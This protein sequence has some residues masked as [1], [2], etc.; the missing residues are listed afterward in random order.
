MTQDRTFDHSVLNSLNAHIAV[1]NKSG[2]IVAVND[3]WTRFAVKNGAPRDSL[4]G[5]GVNYLDVCRRSAAEGD[6]SAAQALSG[7]T[8]VSDCKRQQFRLEYPCHSP[9]QLRWFLLNATALADG[10]GVVVSHEDITAR[11]LAEDVLRQSQDRLEKRIRARTKQLE[12]TNAALREEI[13]QRRIIEMHLRQA[14]TVFESS[15]EA[16]VITDSQFRVQTANCAYQAISGFDAQEVVGESF[17]LQQSGGQGDECYEMIAEALRDSGQWQGEIWNR[18]KNGELYPA[19][20]S[21][22]QV[23][24]EQG[25]TQNYVIAFSDISA[26]KDAEAQLHEL[27]H[28]DPLTGLANRLSLSSQLQAAIERARRHERR[29]ALLFLDLDR[30][31]IINDTLGHAAGDALLKSVAQRLRNLVRGEDIVARWGGDEFVIIAEELCQ[32]ED[33][34]LL[35]G[36]L[37]NGL[38]QIP[39]GENGEFAADVSIGI[40]I[41]PDDADNAEDLIKMADAAMYHAKE[42]G[43]LNYQFYRAELTHQAVEYFALHSDLRQALDGQEFVLH[44]QP[45]VSLHHGRVEAFEALIRWQHPNRGLVLPDTFI[46]IAEETGLIQPIGEWV[47]REA[48]AQMRKWRNQGLPPIRIAVNISGREL[49]HGSLAER[50]PDIIR[51]SGLSGPEMTLDL[52]IKENLQQAGERVNQALRELRAFGLGISIDDFGTGYSSLGLLR[53]L[54]VDTLKIDKSF[55]ADIADN[56]DSRSVVQAILALG[57]SLGLRVVGEGVENA[58]QFEFLRQN[59]C[60]LAQGFFFSEPVP[61]EGLPDLMNQRLPLDE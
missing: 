32:V 55:I 10:E 1:L 46:H 23:C 19:W 37:I 35:A 36:K 5:V 58:A 22:S 25:R 15:N 51:K 3:A 7:I 45:L 31:K 43:R 57:N 59:G 33:S 20:E 48:C 38:T 61:A 44:Y 54:P 47:L 29:I 60:D 53:H 9:E 34:A 16:I 26:I 28:H 17:N 40:S 39:N 12:R 30:F 8:A 18:R 41:Y 52:E 14:A 42:R 2:T 13:E 24:D 27:A 49:L 4:V 11:R 6:E 50:I 56:P 21:I